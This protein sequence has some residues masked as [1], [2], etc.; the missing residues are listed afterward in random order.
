MASTIR[1]AVVG[2][3]AWGTLAHLPSL[4]AHPEVAIAA[5]VDRDEGRVRDAAARYGVP[6]GFTDPDVMWG[7]GPDFDA[8][9]VAT[10]TDTHLPIA[11]PAL[12]AGKHVLCEKP[13]ALDL[14]Q[15]RI[16]AAAARAAARDGVVT[17]VGFMFRSSPALRRMRELV[18]AGHVG[19]VI[20][21]QAHTMNAQFADPATPAHW[22]MDRARANGGVHV[23]Y[24]AHAIDLAL[25][26]AGPIRR[27]VAHART[28]TPAR[29]AAPGAPATVAVE[30]D[31]SAT[32]LAEFASGAQGTFEQSWS[33]FPV[34]GGGVRVYGT[35]GSLAWQPDPTLRRSETLVSATIDDPEPR[36]LLTHEHRGEE[37]V[38]GAGDASRVGGRSIGI[39]R[40][41]N[42]GLIAEFVADI[43]RGTSGDASFEDG[44]RVQ[45]VLDAIGRSLRSERWEDVGGPSAP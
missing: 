40:D 7:N 31:D 9:I 29:P 45:E 6:L 35:R 24:G 43:R 41:Y 15:A 13:L 32:W 30:V 2:L 8:V 19:E 28:V 14:A 10:P 4:A 27:V 23:E 44:L 34:G 36:V 39:S 5:V 21:F 38:P 25:A 26:L 1:V 22:K 17:K 42:D 11:L 18:A 16:M 37:T 20:A 12:A 3:G 33:A